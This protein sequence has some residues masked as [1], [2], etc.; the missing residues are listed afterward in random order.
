M[1]PVISYARENRDRHLELL[2][3]YLRIPSI[4]TDESKAKDVA[5]AARWVRDR[6]KAAGCTKA[7]TIETSDTGASSSRVATAV[8]S[9]NSL[10][11][12]Q[13]SKPMSSSP[14]SKAVPVIVG[15][16]PFSIRGRSGIRAR[17]FVGRAYALL[18]AKWLIG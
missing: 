11:P 8:M 7:E 9:S 2:V 12:P 4:S 14:S 17:Q 13:S 6:L 3:E 1:D 18:I 15:S 5:R 16:T 10:P